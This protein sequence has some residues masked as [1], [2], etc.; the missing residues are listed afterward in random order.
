[1]SRWNPVYRTAVLEPDYRFA[2]EHLLPHFLNV[3]L[4]HALGLER[5]GTPHAADAVQGLRKMWGLCAPVYDPAMEDLFFALDHA[6]YA[7]SPTGA[8]ALRTGLSR[9]DLDMTVYR[10]HAR[11]QWLLAVQDLNALRS[12]LLSLATQELDTLILAYT[13]HQPAQPTLPERGGER[14]VARHGPPR[15]GADAAKS[16]PARGGGARWQQPS[17]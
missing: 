9:N 17:P 16:Q 5:V 13:H 6:L 1:M 10:L 14:A 3:L 12:A 2:S 7:L 15:R 4:A 11:E 8:G